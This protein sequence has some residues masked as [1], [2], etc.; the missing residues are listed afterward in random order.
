[1]LK[2]TQV[3]R[4]TISPSNQE[5]L[6]VHRFHSNTDMALPNNA[7][8]SASN[9]FWKSPYTGDGLSGTSKSV[10]MKPVL[11]ITSPKEKMTTSVDDTS[12]LTVKSIL[13]HKKKFDNNFDN[14]KSENKADHEPQ[15]NLI[16]TGTGKG[17]PHGSPVRAKTC[18]KRVQFN[19]ISN[20]NSA[21]LKRGSLNLYSPTAHAP[22]RR[23]F[24]DRQTSTRILGTPNRLGN[25]WSVNSQNNRNDVASLNNG[26][27]HIKYQINAFIR[28]LRLAENEKH[29]KMESETKSNVLDQNAQNKTAAKLRKSRSFSGTT[30]RPDWTEYDMDKINLSA[31]QSNDEAD[32]CHINEAETVPSVVYDAKSR[33]FSSG[34][35]SIESFSSD[36]EDQIVER[37]PG[38]AK[39]FRPKPNASLY[40]KYRHITT[41]EHVNKY[42]CTPRPKSENDTKR[43]EPVNFCDKRKTSQILCWLE[44]VRFAQKN[45]V[46][47]VSPTEV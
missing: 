42:G 25:R 45:Q 44:E 31:N 11:S 15:P 21:E 24:L 14:I 22:G 20:Q 10:C 7:R 39:V 13:K 33:S 29:T 43:K 18:R 4:E 41:N 27:A 30:S 8:M 36:N 40:T 2:V 47:S 6:F 1:M 16:T 9:I 26:E 35:V 23:L 34:S 19:E 5:N 38:G 12:R 17:K 28:K 46:P 37:T 32:S 3:K